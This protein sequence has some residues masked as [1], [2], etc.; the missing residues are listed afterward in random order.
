MNKSRFLKRHMRLL[1]N[2]WPPFL[3][4]GIRVTKLRPDWQEI[5]VQM[6][7]RRWNSNYV[8]THY[9]GSL[10]SMTD[11]FF[12]LMLIECLG[13]NYI[14]WDRSASI[15]FRK[16]GKGTVSASFRLSD[17]QVA[18]IRQALEIQEKIDK[19]FNVDVRDESGATVAEVEKVLHVRRKARSLEVEEISNG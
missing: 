16:P 17:Q 11:P 7:L 10:Y 19:T 6:K 2:F 9:G 13:P 4:A 18:E 5:E 3:G 8:G 15:R 12:M 1:M 14:V